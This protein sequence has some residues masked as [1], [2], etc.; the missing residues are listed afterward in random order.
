MEI[1]L[2]CKCGAKIELSDPRMYYIDF[3]HPDEYGDVFQIERRAREW[4]Q[5]HKACLGEE[6]KD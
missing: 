5:M 1:K 4:L 2:T 6:H 3:G